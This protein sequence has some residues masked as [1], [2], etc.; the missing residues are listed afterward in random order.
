MLQHNTFDPLC[1]A[2][3]LSRKTSQILTYSSFNNRIPL[4]IICRIPDTRI[5]HA[6]TQT[7]IQK[8]PALRMDHA[9][10]RNGTRRPGWNTGKR[11]VGTECGR[12]I[13][14]AAAVRLSS[15][16]SSTYVA[17]FK[18]YK[19]PIYLKLIKIRLS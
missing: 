15:S 1:D 13:F 3:T 18:V 14:S 8:N 10:Q 19:S 11:N 6:V 17:R 5:T 16:S 12:L 9:S 2:K 7:N 4:D